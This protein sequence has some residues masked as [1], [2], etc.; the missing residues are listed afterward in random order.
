MSA[1]TP[2]ADEA[3]RTSRAADLGRRRTGLASVGLLVCTG[4]PST[5]L[6]AHVLDPGSGW[7]SWVYVY[8]FSAVAVGGVIALDRH[9][10]K[11]GWRRAPWP[12]WVVLAYVA[13]AVLSATWS[14]AADVT[15]LQ[16]SIG[17][18]IAA[19]GLWFGLELRLVEQIWA[20]ALAAGVA[21]VASAVV[22]VVAPEQG[23]M[24]ADGLPSAYWQGIFGNRNSLA[25][26]C[27]LAFVGVVG[28]IALRPKRRRVVAAVPLAGLDLLLL[29]RST[30]A[31]SRIALVAM[32]STLLL[33]LVARRV[34]RGGQ[35]SGTP[36]GLVAGVV[37]TMGVWL[38]VNHIAWLAGRVGRDATLTGRRPIWADVRAAIAVHPVRGYGFWAFWERPD[39]TAASY[40]RLGVYGSAHNS[41]LEVALGL[42]GVGVVLYLG[43][44]LCAIVGVATVAWRGGGSAVWWSVLL[45]FVL[46][47]SSMESFVLWHSYM[48][49]LLVAALAASWTSSPPA[50]VAGAAIDDVE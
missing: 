34:G 43:I 11:G 27:V 22:V 13:L 31:T 29:Q 45:A 26:V 20:T 16:A 7:Q 46:V 42:G 28:V 49:V 48:W 24:F 8:P 36:Y 19:F 50:P 10:P 33:V 3:P 25:P 4:G 39:L 37:L 32:A 18:G 14:V 12:L 23:K 17:V 2:I 38:M 47:Q 40:A 1:A 15:T 44:A 6:A 41:V 21:V 9:R 30:G 35:R 5:Y